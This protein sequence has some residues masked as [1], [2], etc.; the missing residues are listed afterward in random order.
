LTCHYDC[1]YGKLQL[2]VTT[3][4]TD[5]GLASEGLPLP[6]SGSQSW[7]LRLQFPGEPTRA[8]SLR[9]TLKAEAELRAMPYIQDHK[10]KLWERANLLA[11]RYLEV[12]SE[13]PL[14]PG[15]YPGPDGGVILCIGQKLVF[16]DS[17]RTFVREA[18]NRPKYRLSATFD[19]RGIPAPTQV[20]HH[21][22]PAM[23]AERRQKNLA[24]IYRAGTLRPQKIKPDDLDDAIIETWIMDRSIP[25]YEAQKA[26]QTLSLFHQVTGKSLATATRDD[27]R[28]L[29]EVKRT[30]ALKSGTI[31]KHIG[32]LRSAVNIAIKDGKLSSNPFSGIGNS[33]RS[34][35]KDRL[36]FTEDEMA[37][38]GAHLPELSHEHQLLWRFLAATG[39]RLSEPFSITQEF[40]EGSIRYVIVGSK[41]PQS[42]RRIPLPEAVL[43][44][45]PHR[46]AGSLFTKPAK[47]LGKDLNRFIRRAGI[48]DTAK[49][50]HCLRHRAKD[51]LRA[52]ECPLDIQY[53]LLG[54][55]RRTVASGYGTGYPVVKLKGWIDKIGG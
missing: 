13:P 3:G 43:P 17:N 50:L 8:F 46:I 32:L 22:A 15:E 26:R 4:G 6:R 20:I 29:V 9:T 12:E 16:L 55:E 51:R 31:Q 49:V 25:S 11:R 30:E 33:D 28:K 38:L 21:V 34:D 2:D 10:L 44:L 45:L 18:L 5:I 36:P 52:E 24:T 40:T 14:P 47:I 42:R 27:A 53:E 1:L 19:P 54:H 39:M 37:L 41:T 7:W 23:A 48:K 35:Q